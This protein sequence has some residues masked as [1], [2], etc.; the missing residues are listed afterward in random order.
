[1]KM[2]TRARRALVKA[3]WA[4]AIRNL[5]RATLAG[6][7]QW[8]ASAAPD[9]D[10]RAFV[11]RGGLYIPYG[12]RRASAGIEV[13]SEHLSAL[14]GAQ[15]TLSADDAESAELFGRLY[16]AAAEQVAARAGR[17]G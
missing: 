6:E 13:R 4:P 10:F 16:D 15:Y 11:S 3:I 1:M 5:L 2:T 17:Q 8:N 9:E 14:V 12:L 7:V